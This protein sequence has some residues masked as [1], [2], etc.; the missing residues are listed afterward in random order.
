MEYKLGSLFK[1]DRQAWN[2]YKNSSNDALSS[3][4]ELTEDIQPEIVGD[5]NQDTEDVL[6]EQQ[7]QEILQIQKRQAE[8]QDQLED[9]NNKRLSG[10][11][12]VKAGLGNP[13]NI[14]GRVSRARTGELEKYYKELEEKHPVAYNL[15][16]MVSSLPI[17]IVATKGA[18]TIS[19]LNKLKDLLSKS[20]NITKGA[21]AAGTAAGVDSAMRGKTGDELKNLA[22]G[23][24]FGTVTGGA[25][26]LAGKGIKNV[27]QGVL[28]GRSAKIYSN[29]ENR[30]LLKEL[31]ETGTNEYDVL[32]EK[33]ANK[34]NEVEGDFSSKVKKVENEAMTTLKN[35]SKEIQ[36]ATDTLKSE[37]KTTSD[38]LNEKVS[39]NATKAW[40]LLSREET[41]DTAP[42]EGFVDN[43]LAKLDKEL[44]PKETLEVL[45]TLKNKFQK[46]R[47][48]E[49]DLRTALKSLRNRIDFIE[50]KKLGYTSKNNNMLINLD[51]AMNNVLRESNPKYATFV[52]SYRPLV[53]LQQK[54]EYALPKFGKADQNFLS[55][56]EKLFG[57]TLTD[58]LD[59]GS[60]N[61]N[62][63]LDGIVT[64]NPELRKNYENLI[65]RFK[66]YNKIKDT[67]VL[68]NLKN[69]S[70]LA[71]NKDILSS[72]DRL[73]GSK[74]SSSLDN[75]IKDTGID[76]ATELGI[77][78]NPKKAER[79]LRNYNIGF[80]KNQTTLDKIFDGDELLNT[81]K[82]F[83]KKKSSDIL[84]DIEDWLK[85][86]DIKKKTE[87]ENAAINL[88]NYRANGSAE[89]NTLE[90][91]GKVL[92]KLMVG[93]GSIAGASGQYFDDPTMRNIGGAIAAL[94]GLGLTKGYASRGYKLLLD[95]LDKPYIQK[96]TT[97]ASGYF[98][99]ELTKTTKAIEEQ[100]KKNEEYFGRSD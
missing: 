73:Y 34:V 48:S 63:F 100:K 46:G 40:N 72:L 18:G 19:K 37:L 35:E 32:P 96:I 56:S 43:V 62:E 26:G 9:I 87:I 52:D 8:L 47:I 59:L 5:D 6:T 94:G 15:A 24:T 14:A 70:K 27:A 29:P 97:P 64:I 79:L 11:N 3:D 28:G 2:T 75:V 68:D 80:D 99:P 60:S 65:Y 74:T 55:E 33:I 98:I 44:E 41:I 71:E 91:V 42:L 50:P 95:S 84:S 1:S 38:K 58:N 53:D 81:S 89:A 82:N 23:G 16:N 36:K 67:K 57:N 92:P 86:Y 69:S 39:K 88:E 12:A 7:K 49:Y 45:N 83:K 90:A 13:Y 76:K 93:G 51:T 30:K 22:A 78:T 61:F 21:L 17:D 20:S 4:V 10:W 77:F 25:L 31:K 66:D 85:D 54:F